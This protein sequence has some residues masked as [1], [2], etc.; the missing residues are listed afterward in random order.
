VTLSN[1]AL[2]SDDVVAMVVLDGNAVY[3]NVILHINTRTGT[4]LVKVK[5]T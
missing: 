3:R 5:A 1:A 4:T 2:V